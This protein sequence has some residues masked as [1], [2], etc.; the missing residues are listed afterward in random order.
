MTVVKLERS[1]V[2]VERVGSLGWYLHHRSQVFLGSDG[3]VFA[4][5]IRLAIERYRLFGE[6]VSQY[7]RESLEVESSDAASEQAK[8][9]KKLETCSS[10][11]ASSII[12]AEY[13]FR[14]RV[15][16]LTSPVYTRAT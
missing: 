5:Q 9:Y 8:L 16:F 7:V 3:L 10:V 6:T 4:V 14:F 13:I 12:D 2:W 11:E 15:N 1:T